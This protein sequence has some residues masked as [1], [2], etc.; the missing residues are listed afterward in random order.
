MNRNL[1]GAASLCLGILVFS[2]Q[3]G[4]IKLISGDYAVTQAVF[5]RSVVALPILL[6]LV[7]AEGGFGRLRTPNVWPL[8]LRGLIMLLAYTTY[9]MAFPALPLASAIALFFVAPL[10]VTALAGPMLGERIG[11]RA[12]FAVV[13]GFVGVLVMTRPGSGVFEP[14]AL[15]SLFAA[16]CYAFAMVYARK[17]GVNEP[18]S[19]MASYQ[20]WTYLAG[21]AVAAGAFHGLG[22]E[23]APHPSLDFLVRPWVVPPLFDLGLM[24]LCGV[25]AAIAIFLL[26]YA[27]RTAEA[28]RVTVF[29][30]TG[31]IWGALWGYLFFDEIPSLWIVAGAL[32]I[33]AA[34]PIALSRDR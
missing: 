31:L 28:K 20:N 25:A 33:F 27:Y 19:V 32:M 4:I 21:A 2:I 7:R 24:A 10:L 3:D 14:A 5:V 13:L 17:L 23:S 26:T 30:Y 11:G 15:L 29:E 22:I 6:V 16:A 1:L 8:T 34:G 12:I 9:Y 18:A